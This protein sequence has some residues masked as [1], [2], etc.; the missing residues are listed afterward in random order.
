MTITTTLTAPTSSLSTTYVTPSP[1]STEPNH[2]KAIIGGVV[3]SVVFLIGANLLFFYLRSRRKR[4]TTFDASLVS[5]FQEATSFEDPTTLKR[6]RPNL[7]AT[8]NL[9]HSRRK[10]NRR[11]FPLFNA[12]STTETRE[13]P[14]PSRPTIN[15]NI[16]LAQNNRDEDFMNNVQHVGIE[17]DSSPVAYRHEDSGWRNPTELRNG[18]N[19]PEGRERVELPPNYSEV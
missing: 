18:R 16:R 19:R 11:V 14:Q 12:S 7:P 3:G 9:E 10:G 17:P 15:D 13:A 5:P 6:E 8:L 4:A 2:T 1:S